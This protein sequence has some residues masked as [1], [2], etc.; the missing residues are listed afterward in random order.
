MV[1]QYLGWRPF[2]RGLDWDSELAQFP[3]GI[4]AV[5][6]MWLS[7]V[8]ESPG[9]QTA[10]VESSLPGQSCRWQRVASWRSYCSLPRVAAERP[11]VLAL[12]PRLLVQFQLHSRFVVLA[13]FPTWSSAAFHLK[14]KIIE[15]INFQTNNSWHF[16]FIQLYSDAYPKSIY[17]TSVRLQLQLRFSEYIEWRRTVALAPLSLIC[18]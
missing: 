7:L 16:L 2:S 6:V 4:L 5:Q 1:F 17:W 13:I 8:F 12:A 3:A 18:K 15:I 9:R 11:E 10:A 14:H